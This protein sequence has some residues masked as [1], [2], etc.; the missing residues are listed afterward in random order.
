[1][2]SGSQFR[3]QD[4]TVHCFLQSE[5]CSEESVSEVFSWD[6]G[7]LQIQTIWHSEEAAD[8]RHLEL[9]NSH[10][11]YFE[12]NWPVL[13]WK[14]VRFDGVLLTLFNESFVLNAFIELLFRWLIWKQT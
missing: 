8:W 14:L 1:M 9:Q 7:R 4:Q 10:S 13:T 5:R 2:L 11:V 3:V 6:C 12:R